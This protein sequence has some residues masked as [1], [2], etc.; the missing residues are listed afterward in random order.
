MS[1]SNL[2][3]CYRSVNDCI[4]SRVMEP[5]YHCAFLDMLKVMSVTVYTCPQATTLAGQSDGPEIKQLP[6][7]Q[8]HSRD[9]RNRTVGGPVC[10][11]S[12]VSRPVRCIA[13]TGYGVNSVL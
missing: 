13:M 5:I 9:A 8:A 1:N 4:A 7:A 2:S 6:L 3:R 10:K 12:S 11:N